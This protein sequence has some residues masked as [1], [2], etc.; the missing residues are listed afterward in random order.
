MN[1]NLPLQNLKPGLPKLSIILFLILFSFSTVKA[2]NPG[3]QLWASGLPAGVYPKLSIAPNHDI[4]YGVLGTGGAKGIIY[5]ANTFDKVI[6]FTALPTIPIPAS[7]TNNIQTIITNVNNEPIVGIFRSNPADP[8]LFRFDNTSQ[9]WTDVTVD[10]LPN[11][12]AFCNAISPN[13]TIW[14]GTKWSYIYKST[15][16]GLS[17]K[18]IDE[19]PIV[20]ASYPCYYPTWHGNPSDGAI[21]SINV[22]KNG[23]V[24]A[25]TEGAGIIFSDDDGIS[26]H[27]ADYH[28]CQ[29]GNPSLKDSSS[30]MKPLSNTGNLGALGFTSDNNL[31]FNGTSLWDFN[32]KTSLGFADMSAES[33]TEAKGFVD[34]FIATGLQVTKI[35]TTDNG[36]IF[37]HSGSNASVMGE[38]GIYTSTDGINWTAFNNGITSGNNGQAQGSLAVDGDRVFMATTDGKIWMY[39]AGETTSTENPEIQNQLNIFP[40]IVSNEL[41]FS[42]P[43][44]EYQVYNIFGQQVIHQEKSAKSTSVNE[45]S[46]GV[47]FL[48]AE[49]ELLKFIVIH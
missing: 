24:Y 4:F 45:L 49:N 3:W 14:V 5:K 25:G 22:D 36:K 11:L 16:N 2:Q 44:P 41:Y 6:N 32:W 28:A 38:I 30:T 40:T 12:G 29:S 27:P 23:R 10:N 7:I 26:W 43:L 34:Y 33:T 20:K 35:V 8:F 17:F 31:I 37:L 47:Y 1:N 18:R 39:N 15:D 13:G 9:T 48:K 46:N 19:T 42:K 21:Y